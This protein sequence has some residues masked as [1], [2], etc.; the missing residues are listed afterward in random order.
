MKTVASIEETL[1]FLWFLF[2]TDSTSA[3][4][5][6]VPGVGQRVRDVFK[7]CFGRPAADQIYGR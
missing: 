3:A 1:E 6:Q 7:M 5:V 2:L 4:K